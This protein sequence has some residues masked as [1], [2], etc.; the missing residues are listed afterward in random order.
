MSKQISSTD[1]IVSL[2][3]SLSK[4]MRRSFL[5]R[6]PSSVSM[7]QVKV[8]G[9]ISEHSSQNMKSVA[10]DL[11][12]TPAA[13]TI[14]IDKLASDGLIKKKTDVH[15][16]RV[17]RLILTAK[18]REYLRHGMKIFREHIEEVTSVLSP[19]EKLQLTAILSKL[20]N[21]K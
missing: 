20:V 13:I 4:N 7:L 8:L 21:K 19:T 1:D 16:K 9:C 6:L 2:L 11:K 14:I 12:V 3:I 10:E 17:T 5:A 18:G 15:D